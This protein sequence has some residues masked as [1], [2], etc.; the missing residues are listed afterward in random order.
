MVKSIIALRKAFI[1][2]LGVFGSVRLK[3]KARIDSV[4]VSSSMVLI[5]LSRSVLCNSGQI[6][7][8]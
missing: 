4:F 1:L 2:Y 8:H 5:S 3:A 7:L 6:H